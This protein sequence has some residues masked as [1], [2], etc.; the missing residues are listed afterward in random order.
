[1]TGK[2]QEIVSLLAE[3]EPEA[4]ADIK[5]SSSYPRLTGKALFY[6][7]WTGTLVFIYAAGLPYSEA[8]CPDN[9]CA[10][11]IHGGNACTGTK[12]EPFANAGTHYNPANCPHPAHA[13]DLPPLFSNHGAA[14]QMFYTERF[15]PQDIIGKTAII[16]RKPDDFTTQ[17]SGNPGEMIACGVI[18]K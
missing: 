1:M 8:K 5:G 17:P 3:C 16:H 7:F 12:E 15:T 4:Y 14:M 11:H 9:I 13:G 10:F 18:K 6:P 2:L